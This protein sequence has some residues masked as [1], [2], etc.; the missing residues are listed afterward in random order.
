MKVFPLS[1]FRGVR[2]RGALVLA[3]LVVLGA[4]DERPL[5]LPSAA[6][7]V[8]ETYEVALVFEIFDSEDDGAAVPGAA[9][10][11]YGENGLVGIF[12]DGQDLDN[13]NNGRIEILVPAGQYGAM[14]KKIPVETQTLEFVAPVPSLPVVTSISGAPFAPLAIGVEEEWGCAD[15]EAVSS[16][17]TAL[18]IDASEHF[19]DEIDIRSCDFSLLTVEVAGAQPGD[20]LYGVIG[21][22]GLPILGLGDQNGFERGIL[23][24]VAIVGVEGANSFGLKPKGGVAALASP[25][26]FATLVCPVGVNFAVELFQTVNVGGTEVNRVA[27]LLQNCGGAP[28]TATIVTEAAQCAVESDPT[29]DATFG[30]SYWGYGF[31]RGDFDEGEP[32]KIL[33]LTTA[34]TRF[35]V[36]EDGKY[37][38]TFRTDRL[39]GGRLQ[40]DAEF[41]CA[42]GQC[43]AGKTKLTGGA[44]NP[45]SV[46]LFFAPDGAGGVIVEAVLVDIPAHSELTWAMNGPKGA[47]RPLPPRSPYSG[48]Y[49]P[50]R[51][52]PNGTSNPVDCTQDSNDGTW[53]VRDL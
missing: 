22:G 4:C 17:T 43:T 45:Q 21:T 52:V 1:W 34:S 35:T 19:V 40:A 10:W 42:S 12:N 47:K 44:N 31:Q 28:A 8:V 20:P 46:Q 53:S 9:L 26:L 39:S 18:P 13:A 48:A 36:L 15:G 16:T 27:S 33:D 37:S 49:Y 3:S 50:F 51:Q 29:I 38:V 6:L 11:L 7:D 30:A 23:G 32:A 25:S 14:I 2:V 5:E 41:T 24:F